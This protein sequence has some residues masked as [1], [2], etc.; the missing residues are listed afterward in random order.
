MVLPPHIIE[1][2]EKTPDQQDRRVFLLVVEEAVKATGAEAGDPEE[3]RG[4]IEIQL[5]GD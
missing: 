1:E 5:W 4:V 2:V 3:R